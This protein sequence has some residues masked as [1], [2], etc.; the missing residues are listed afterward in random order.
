VPIYQA[1]VLGLVQG[2]SE[3]LPISSSAHLTLVPW[4][5]GWQDP[6]LAFDVALHFGTLLALLWYFRKEWLALIAAAV[7]I[8]RQRRVITSE[9]RRLIHL[10]VATV[11]AA[12]AGLALERRAETAFRAPALIAVMLML[13]GVL[14]WAADRIAA[15]DR[16]LDDMSWRD[17][18]LIGVAQSFALIPGV[19]RSG[20]TITAARLLRLDRTSA[21]VF[22][23][24]LSMPV[25]AAAAVLK[26]PDALRAEGVSL[27]VLAGI[28]AATASS[29]LAIT[30]LL[31]YV[32]RHSYGVFAL[33]RLLLG[34]AVLLLVATRG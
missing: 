24:M 14:L 25:I 5:F 19:S 34:A 31:R 33:Y 2:F 13:M 30:V 16:R 32:S 7:R 27:P 9:E 8:L 26:M 12:V 6:G 20:S 28:V 11:P 3:F 18:L 22:S 17:A 21:A 23:F 29:W 1:I 15:A 4:A 10:I